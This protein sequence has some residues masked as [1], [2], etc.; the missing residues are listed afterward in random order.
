MWV[1]YSLFCAPWAHVGFYLQKPAGVLRRSTHLA[2]NPPAVHTETAASWW[3]FLLDNL[4]F[5]P[6]NERK[7]ANTE[8]RWQ[9]CDE[10]QHSAD[11]HEALFPLSLLFSDVSRL[12]RLSSFLFN[13]LSVVDTTHPRVTFVVN[14]KRAWAACR[15]SWFSFQATV[16]SF[17][18]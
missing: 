16:H 15:F 14:I 5:L 2:L 1:K 3:F 11:V 4:V 13:L 7:R 8:R 18:L 12:G 10:R 17:T 6:E 9:V